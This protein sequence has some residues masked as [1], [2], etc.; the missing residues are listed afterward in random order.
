[1]KTI[2]HT[3]LPLLAALLLLASCG[4]SEE[5]LTATRE[6]E[7]ET[8]ADTAE[9]GPETDPDFSMITIGEASPVHTLDPLHAVNN[10]T[11]RA[12][13]LVYEGLMRYDSDGQLQPVLARDWELSDDSLTYR[14]SL[15]TDIYYHDSEIFSTGVGRRL[16]AGDVRFS[17]ERM[18]WNSV[19]SHA[20]RTFMNIEGFEPFYREQHGVFNPELRHLG[21]IS[22]IRVPNDSTVVFHLLEPDPWFLHKLASPHAVVYPPEAITSPYPSQF[23]AVGTGPFRYRQQPEDSLFVFSRFDNYRT[24]ETPDLNRVDLRIYEDETSLFQAYASGDVHFIPQSGPETLSAVLEEDGSLSTGYE[25]EH[26][27]HRSGNATRYTLHYHD[28]GPLSPQEARSLLSSM[29]REIFGG[30]FPYA[31]MDIYALRGPTGSEVAADS[32]FAAFTDDLYLR[33]FISRWSA[34]LGERGIDLRMLPVRVPNRNTAFYTGQWTPLYFADTPPPDE[35]MVVEFTLPRVSLYHSDISG[36]GLN[37]YP[38][39]MNLRETSMPDEEAEAGG[40]P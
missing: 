16:L 39:W 28:G 4:S 17:F 36:I 13:Q 34:N 3:Y 35:H 14:F 24:G 8:L 9:A 2:R 7:T 11:R 12:V 21:G 23:P 32:V 22:G 6:A 27:M 29:E 10:A 26:V 18:A 30:E 25:G 5:T 19:P 1:M 20:A 40:R 31:L 37:A 38:W 33:N 15:R